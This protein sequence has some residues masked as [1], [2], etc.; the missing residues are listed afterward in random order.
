[1]KSPLEPG[2]YKAI[3]EFPG[4]SHQITF[5]QLFQGNSRIFL[6]EI[7]ANKNIVFKK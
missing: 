7:V 2:S 6:G 1:M 4:L 5:D 3:F